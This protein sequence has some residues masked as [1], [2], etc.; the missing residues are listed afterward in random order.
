MS[1]IS[2][3]PTKF[4]TA[5][6]VSESAKSWG[7]EGREEGR[8]QFSLKKDFEHLRWWARQWDPDRNVRSASCPGTNIHVLF[9]SGRR[10]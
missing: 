5:F 10:Q 8:F 4:I 7:G 3:F 9:L 2:T 6:G 1:V